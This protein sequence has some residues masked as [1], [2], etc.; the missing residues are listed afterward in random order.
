MNESE[1]KLNT[2][3][4]ELKKRIVLAAMKAF[5]TNGIKG[6]TMDDVASDLGISKRTLYETFKDKEELLIECV[7]L[8]EEE[9]EAFG[10]KAIAESNNV[11]E[12]ILKFYKLSID[13]YQK[14][15][16]RFFE[17]IRKY[18]KVNE[19]IKQSRE[20][21]QCSVLAFFKNGVEQGIFRDDV[22]FEIVNVLIREQMDFLHSAE[23]VR[24][25]SFFEVYESIVFIFLRGISTE[26]GQ[27]ILNEFIGNYRKQKM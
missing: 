24:A 8:Q 6:V 4:S 15:N 9:K 20:K 27:K 7:K 14:I 10:A 2:A 3:K 1:K 23:I 25:Y 18:P 26:K 13:I 5:T 19:L 21:N 16:F 22:N 11:L 17:D 12:V